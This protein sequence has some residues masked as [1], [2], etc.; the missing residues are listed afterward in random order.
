MSWRK[1]Q[2]GSQD[3]QGSCKPGEAFSISCSV[4]W[5]LAHSLRCLPSLPPPSF[6]GPE[7]TQT[8]APALPR[9][10]GLPPEKS[11]LSD[12]SPPEIGQP[13]PATRK[14]DCE[15]KRVY[16]KGPTLLPPRS[17]T[18]SQGKSFLVRPRMLE[19]AGKCCSASS[20]RTRQSPHHISRT[21]DA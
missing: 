17:R 5:E 1:G 7:E 18:P 3:H 8:L 16:L 19:G 14:G 21:Q 11:P 12:P 6:R 15:G 9:T 20:K 13:C 2:G 4:G 10:T